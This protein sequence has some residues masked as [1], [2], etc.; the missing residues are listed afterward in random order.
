MKRYYIIIILLIAMSTSCIVSKK[1]ASRKIAK[2]VENYPSLVVYDTIK[3]VDTIPFVVKEVKHDTIIEQSVDSII[4][5]KDRLRIKY[6]KRDSLVYLS[7][8]CES[9]TIW[10][11]V[12]KEV[13]VPNIEVVKCQTRNNLRLL[14]VFASVVI[15]GFVLKK[16]LK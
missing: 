5:K 8:E 9:D 1:R 2:Y 11:I 3:L 10:E 12:H 6:V 13:V 7:G 15:I 16:L 4:I 14:I